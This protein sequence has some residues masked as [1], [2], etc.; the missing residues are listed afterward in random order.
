GGGHILSI[1]TDLLKSKKAKLGRAAEIYAKTGIALRDGL[2]LAFKMK[3][4]HN[5]I[6]PVSY[7]QEHIDPDWQSYLPTPPYPEYPS[8]LSGI[9]SPTFQVLIRE[10]GD[11][12]V[13]DNMY[14]WRGV[15]PR[16]YDSISIMDK[17]SA[18]SRVYAGLH[19]Q[20]TM[21]ITREI[22]RKLGNQIANMKLVPDK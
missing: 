17:E 4:E 9:Y 2:F 18:R 15:A 6:R 20:F 1:I 12:P 14:V 10:F 22:G 5:L 8:G 7:I 3:Y 16:R 11:I 21:D 19:Y 13:T